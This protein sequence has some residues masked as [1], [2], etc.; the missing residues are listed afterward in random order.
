M[1]GNNIPCVVSEGNIWALIMVLFINYSGRERYC[2][3]EWLKMQ[4]S[5]LRKSWDKP[6]QIPIFSFYF[7]PK[8]HKKT[9]EMHLT[10]G[11]KSES[12]RKTDSC[13]AQNNKQ[14]NNNSVAR[15]LF[16]SFL[17][18]R[19]HFQDCQLCH[20]HAT[21]HKCHT[22]VFIFLTSISQSHK[23]SE[24]HF[25]CLWKKITFFSQIDPYRKSIQASKISGKLV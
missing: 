15:N 5:F 16:A 10:A 7:F 4:G 18:L 20:K 19:R 24:R 23:N 21:T 17:L 3:Y 22:S 6:S 9:G 11:F 1:K 2:Q 12:L 8:E 25:Y 13:Q 14:H